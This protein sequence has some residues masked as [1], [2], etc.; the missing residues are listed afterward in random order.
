MIEEKERPEVE[1]EAVV[2]AENMPAF[3]GGDEA[4]MKYMHD[5]VQYPSFERELGLSGTVYVYF[6]IN[7]LG[8]VQDAKVIRGVK[9]A[10]GLDE[11]AL[12]VINNMPDWLPGTHGGKPVKVQF[13][14]PVAFRLR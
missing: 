1:K 10:K 3:V 8:K 13:T 14:Y 5:N 7:K 2:F 9:G 4:L 11:E 12:R 6:V